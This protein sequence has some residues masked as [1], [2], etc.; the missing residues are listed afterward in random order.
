MDQQ[1][2]I[3]LWAS[4]AGQLEME[5][6]GEPPGSSQRLRWIGDQLENYVERWLAF[7]TIPSLPMSSLLDDDLFGIIDIGTD[8]M[9]RE[10]THSAENPERDRVWQEFHSV[11]AMIRTV[12][13]RTQAEQLRESLAQYRAT[14]VQ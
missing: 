4:L 3:E 7:C 9:D 8:L 5:Q 14:L 6:P 1:R 13:E 10:L 2:R 11:V 12:G